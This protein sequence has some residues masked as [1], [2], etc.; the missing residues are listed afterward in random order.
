MSCILRISGREL[1]VDDLIGSTLMIPDSV[2]RKGP[3]PDSTGKE[4]SGARFVASEA[5]FSEPSMQIEEAIAFLRE[6]RDDLKKALSFPG[7]ECAEL[8]FGTEMRQSAYGG[9][10]LPPELLSLAGGLGVWICLS[11]YPISEL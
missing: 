1:D 9:F 6:N 2:W 8:D 10:R 4:T 3:S 11:V 7:V 5:D